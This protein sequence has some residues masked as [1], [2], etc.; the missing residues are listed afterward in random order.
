MYR[1]FA[2]ISLSCLAACAGSVTERSHKV[3][4]I[5]EPPNASCTLERDGVRTRLIGGTPLT[6]VVTRDSGDIEVECKLAGY[7]KTSGTLRSGLEPLLIGNVLTG[8][9]VGLVRDI[10]TGFIHRYPGRITIV[11]PPIPGMTTEQR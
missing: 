4:V 10:G 11:L 7:Q 8:G 2:I 1:I 9:P 5:T 3:T 6:F